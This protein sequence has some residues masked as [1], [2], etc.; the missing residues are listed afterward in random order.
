MKSLQLFVAALV[1]VVIAACSKETSFKTLPQ[2]PVQHHLI[3]VA[4]AHKG[5]RAQGFSGATPPNTEIHAEVGKAVG[6]VTSNAD[7]S[8][9]I[10]LADADHAH[11][12]GELTFT[13]NKKYYQQ[14]Y[15]VR[16][17][18]KS[19]MDMTRD[20][21]E[22]DKEVDAIGFFKGRVAIISSQANLMRTFLVDNRF[23][24]SEE[25]N[26]AV[27]LGTANATPLYP[28]SVAAVGDHLAVTLN[29]SHEVAIVN[30]N[31]NAVMVRAKV[32]DNAGKTFTF[33][34]TTPL[35]VKN[36][37]DAD[38]SGTA[39]T[40]ITT[41]IARNPEAMLA[42][43][44]THFLVSFSNYYQFEESGLGQKAVVGPGVVA[45][46]AIEKDAVKTKAREV[47]D[48]KNPRHFVVK[49]KDNV[50]LV[51]SGA[52]SNVG[53]SSLASTDAGLIRLKIAADRASFTVDHRL[54]LPNFTPAI[55]A[56]VDTKLVIPHADRNEIA[57]IDENATSINKSDIK[58]PNFH[59]E[60][61][62][63]FAHYW[64]DG[65]VFLGDA[66]GTLVAYSVKDG[67]FPFPFVEPL[68]IDRNVDERIGLRPQSMYLRSTVDGVDIK[69]A[70]PLGYNAWIVSD[71][72]QKIYPMDFLSVFGP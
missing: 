27:M 61:A 26:T 66:K 8:F 22:T 18:A 15:K 47:L 44:D 31:A 10:D 42:L 67:Y 13:I 53:S 6:K 34:L 60:F 57:V 37:I 64:H 33:A 40:T 7:G 23:R 45:L 72:H 38:L 65:I 16:D 32:E 28:S 25:P 68:I 17:L 35:T 41:S 63:T 11:L 14:G 49:D 43:D 24:L 2:G 4:K 62:F 71:S 36:P 3:V 56:L 19:L 12:A 30:N 55:L 20:G 59:R 29:L 1:L 52:W 46:M 21:F 70:P 54:A 5:V 51:C 58:E 50:L 69:L 39:K 9:A 48:F